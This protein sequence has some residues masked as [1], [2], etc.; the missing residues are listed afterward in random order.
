MILQRLATSIRK[1][2]WFTVVIETL[3]V[4]FG[5]YLGIQLGNWNGARAERAEGEAL[6]ERLY[7]ELTTSL[8][9]EAACIARMETNLEQARSV[10]EMLRTGEL[11]DVS[12][13]EFGEQFV[14]IGPWTG[15][16]VTR[17]TLDQLEGGQI[18]LVSDQ[19]LKDQVLQFADYLN[20]STTTIDNLG[21]VH[22]NA[23]E[24]IF[25]EVDFAWD[26]GERRLV[27]S[28][29]DAAENQELVRQLETV[30]FMFSVIVRYHKLANEDLREMHSALAE[31]LG[32]EAEAAR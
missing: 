21:D 9:T 10:Y 25:A 28:F 16:C 17:A 29:E 23:L 30:T 11:G 12:E 8:D 3:I 27:T 15:L 22:M 20:G 4:V 18:R 19:A 1:Q 6:V 13:D 5:V 32:E 2:D 7:E 24:K 26:G 14:A 31:Y